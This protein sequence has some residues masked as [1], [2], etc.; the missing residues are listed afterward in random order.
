MMKY[1]KKNIFLYF[2]L[3]IIVLWANN[4][5]YTQEITEY[6][7]PSKVTVGWSYVDPT[8]ISYYE[9]K[10]VKEDQTTYAI[11]TTTERQ[12]EVT[13]PD[14]GKYIVMIRAVKVENGVPAYSDWGSSVDNTAKLK[15]GTLGKWK[16]YW[17]QEVT[18][19]TEYISPSRVT[20]IWSHGNPIAVSYYEIKIIRDDPSQTTYAIGT[21]TETQMEI[22]KPRSG[23]YV[24]MVRA[25][26]VEN[27]V[28]AY[29][30]WGSSVD[31]TAKLK[32]GTLGKWKVYWKPSGPVGPFIIK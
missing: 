11:G 4:S 22:T 1:F 5:A 19:I 8:T 13:K 27:G 2:L 31:N 3:I 23:K 21:T 32:D 17:Q 18:T 6:I 29:S 16:V 30:D 12:I 10:I 28:P 24:V 9:I 7:S 26:K 25:V 14:V 15:D 20:I